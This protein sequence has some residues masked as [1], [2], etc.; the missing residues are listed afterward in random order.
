M[1]SLI[2]EGAQFQGLFIKEFQHEALSK[3][4]ICHPRGSGLEGFWT[5][6][7]LN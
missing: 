1:G 2:A 6:G 7:V 5:L 3:L 4:G